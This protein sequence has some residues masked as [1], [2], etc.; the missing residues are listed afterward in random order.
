ML[1]ISFLKQRNALTG[2]EYLDFQD[3]SFFNDLTLIFLKYGKDVKDYNG[4]ATEIERCIEKHTGLKTL[5]FEF[6]DGWAVE[7]DAAALTPNQAISSRWRNFVNPDEILKQSSLMKWFKSNKDKIF[8]G[9]VDKRT[10][11]FEGD[12][13]T[14]PVTIKFG[15]DLLTKLGEEAKFEE[16]AACV[17]HEV[18]HI[19]GA[20]LTVTNLA[21]DSMITMISISL[22]SKAEDP[23]LKVSIVNDTVSL[24][25]IKENRDKEDIQIKSP[26]ELSLFLSKSLKRRDQ[27]RNLSLG[28]QDMN[29]ESLADLYCSRMGCSLALIKVISEINKINHQEHWK[30]IFKTFALAVFFKILT[31]G[32]LFFAPGIAV[33]FAFLEVYFFVIF[34]IFFL[35]YIFNSFFGGYVESADY[36]TD[37]RRMRTSLQNMISELKNINMTREQ[38]IELI[39]DIENTIKLTEKM[40]PIFENGM[41]KRIMGWI[42]NT[43]DFKYRQMEQYTNEIMNHPI[44]VLNAKLDIL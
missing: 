33:L 8:T 27:R 30:L 25:D 15:K 41:L 21:Y 39:G 32:T 14:L 18:G 7:M 12:F 31:F 1:D 44:N 10:A 28:I 22:M 42:S 6:T 37:Y 19:F 3:K 16:M 2:T 38:K 35:G 11:R 23:N 17:I 40:K 43:S 13:K 20:C 26:V 29:C 5:T 36:D 34:S 24:L 4:M 9:W